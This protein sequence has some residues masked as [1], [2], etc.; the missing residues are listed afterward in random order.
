MSPGD[1]HGLLPFTPKEHDVRIARDGQIYYVRG[2]KKG[3]PLR[4]DLF[5]AS[6]LGEVIASLLLSWLLASWWNRQTTWKVG[7]LRYPDTAWGGRLRIAH[8]EL[9]PPG[10]QPAAR[11]AELVN[12]VHQGRFD[13]P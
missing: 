7:V 8:K 1:G 12:Q 6:G 11:I 9:L 5:D 2:V 3:E 4:S 13:P 10:E